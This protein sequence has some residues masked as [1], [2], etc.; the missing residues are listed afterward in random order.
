LNIAKL[1]STA[2]EAR[3][4]GALFSKLA[5]SALCHDRPHAAEKR[6]GGVHER[7][8]DPRPIRGSDTGYD[9]RKSSSSLPKSDLER[10]YRGMPSRTFRPPPH[11]QHAMNAP[12]AFRTKNR[13]PYY[14]TRVSARRGYDRSTEDHEQRSVAG[15]EKG[16]MSGTGRNIAGGVAARRLRGSGEAAFVNQSYRAGECMQAVRNISMTKEASDNDKF[17]GLRFLK[18]TP[19][20]TA[21]GVSAAERARTP[22]HPRSSWAR[23]ACNV[24]TDADDEWGRTSKGGGAR[25]GTC[26]TNCAIRQVDTAVDV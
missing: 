22:A 14:D 18:R 10:V 20:S 4:P 23:R 19:T 21:G 11:N 1:A 8:A 25:D 5:S 15:L 2:A 13:S 9:I 3:R 16:C 12:T 26:A 17:V 6:A 7:S 24:I